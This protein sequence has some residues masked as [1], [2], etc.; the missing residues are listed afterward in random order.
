LP[1]QHGAAAKKALE[2]DA[3]RPR[4]TLVPLLVL[5]DG[6]VL[7]DSWQIANASGLTPLTDASLVELYDARLGPDSRQLVY[8]FLLK[9]GNRRTFDALVCDARFGKLWQGL[10]WLVGDK[11]VQQMRRSFKVGD[12]QA[13]SECRARLTHTLED[14]AATRLRGRQGRFIGG[15]APGVEDIALCALVAPI[16]LPPLYCNGAFSE[17]FA[18]LEALDPE[19]AAEVDFFRRTDVGKYCLD[20]YSG[21][22]MK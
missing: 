8:A 13:Y 7:E 16:V 5:P 21:I 17:Q 19:V 22:R 20:V 10:W 2:E 11:V 18:A 15:D 3:A 9:P 6:T 12:S 1:E 4:S 14:I